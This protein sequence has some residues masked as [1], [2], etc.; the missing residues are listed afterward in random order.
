MPEGQ[1]L[2]EGLLRLGPARGAAEELEDLRYRWMLYKSKL[3]D[4]G[5][6][7]VGAGGQ[8]IGGGGRGAYG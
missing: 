7:L 5:Q 4:A 8:S 3:K 2:F 6:L 1:R